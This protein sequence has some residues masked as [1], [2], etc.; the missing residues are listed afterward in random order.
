[1]EYNAQKLLKFLVNKIE[2]GNIRANDPSTYFGYKEVLTSLDL[3]HIADTFGRSLELQGLRDL[4]E[5]IEQNK[6]PAIT[7]LIVDKSS[8]MPSKGYFEVYGKERDDFKWWI[9]QIEESI[10]FDWTSYIG[11]GKNIGLLNYANDNVKSKE[12]KESFKKTYLLTWNPENWDWINIKELSEKVR[13]G[14]EVELRWNCR[15]EKVK[16]GDRLF[17]IKQ[18]V[19]PKG[20]FASG[21]CVEEPFKDKH[22]DPKRQ[23]KDISYIRFKVESLL[24]PG[25]DIL[26]P[27]YERIPSYLWDSQT[28]GINLP[29]NIAKE[30]EKQWN[31]FNQTTSEGNKHNNNQ[32]WN[33]AGYGDAKNNAIV[34]KAAIKAVTKLYIDDGWEVKSVEA[35]RCGYDL[36]C[37][38]GQERN[39][40]E[41][42]GISGAICN[43]IITYGEV[44][45]AKTNKQFILCVVTNATSEPTI[46][47]YDSNEFLN[48]F[49]INPVQYRATLK[50]P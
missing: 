28:S 33:G 17:L 4:A 11:N 49:D 1:M 24:A 5:W 30:L 41:V 48:R 23:D 39:D 20:I 13:I 15:S 36:V 12:N 31:G 25:I 16:L 38:R 10:K 8:S 43:F 7:G 14:E 32:N 37:I 19:E 22:Y 9:N 6:F 29:N 26:F 42:K 35:E 47:K 40:V 44:E 46:H 21:V 50:V 34:E 18:G 27:V 3:P 2:E 45:Q